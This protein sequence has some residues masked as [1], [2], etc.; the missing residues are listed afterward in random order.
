MGDRLKGK[1]ALISGGASGLGEA[2]ALLYA[3]EGAMVMI[4]DLQDAIDGSTAKLAS[5]G[6]TLSRVRAELEPD[7]TLIG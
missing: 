2:Q 3:R 5:I 4:G 7:R 6:E 1:V